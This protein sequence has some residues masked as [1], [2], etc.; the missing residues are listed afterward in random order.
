MKQKITYSILA[1]AAACGMALGQTAYTT[2]VGYITIPILGTGGVGTQKIQIANQG[3]LPSGAVKYAGVAEAITSTYV[4]DTQGTWAAGDYLHAGSLGPMV[5]H[6]VEITNGPL[7]GTMTW[8][9][10]TD[11]SSGAGQRLYTSDDISA[12]GDTASFRVLK[13]FD[14]SSLFGVIPA[15]T[16]LG[17]AGTITAADT[18]QIS[19]PLGTPQTFWYKNAGGSTSTWGWKASTLPSG[20]GAVDVPKIAIHPND[21]IMIY[22]KQSG[23]GSLVISGDVKTQNTRVRV[24][25]DTTNASVYNIIANQLPVDSLTISETGLY[26]GDAA[27]GIKGA[28]TITAADTIQIWVPASG[29]FQSFWYKN[30]GGATSTWGWKTAGPLT[31]PVPDDFVIPSVNAVMIQRKNGVPFTWDIPAVVIGQ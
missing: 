9:T 6:L 14:V 5:S 20:V 15:A 22:R 19:D 4:E 12:A 21:G 11:D 18:A 23:N 16:V 24:E 25:G 13:T 3:L 30:A 31:V 2:P 17:G 8:I 26:T 1:A 29:A 28:G 7:Q 10:A 27:T